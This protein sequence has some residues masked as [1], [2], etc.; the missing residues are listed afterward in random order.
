[1]IET[2]EQ[3]ER[4]NHKRTLELRC[5]CQH[6]DPD[7]YDFGSG[8]DQHRICGIGQEYCAPCYGC[9]KVVCEQHRV[10]IGGRDWCFACAK[11][12]MDEDDALDALLSAESDMERARR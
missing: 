6:P 9:H 7:G 2:S 12:E 10:M 11:V 1:M 5:S 8:A 3:I 4:A